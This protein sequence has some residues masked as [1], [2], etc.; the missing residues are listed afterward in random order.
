MPA[1]SKSTKTRRKPLTRSE[2][3][4]RVKSRNSK[5]ERALRSAL[6]AAGLRFRLHRR[7]EG[8]TVDIIF[9]GPKV[10]VLVDG[11]FWHGCPTHATYPKSNQDYWLPKLAENRDRDERQSARPGMPGGA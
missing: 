1:K 5:A 10:A 3:M 2:I 6:H 7:V 8:V 11:C 4:S 9:P